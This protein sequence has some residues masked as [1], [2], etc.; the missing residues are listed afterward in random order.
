MKIRRLSRPRSLS[1]RLAEWPSI[2]TS[3]PLTSRSQVGPAR[4]R[5]Q[6]GPVAV[7]GAVVAFAVA[8]VAGEAAEIPVE[9]LA[10]QPHPVAQAERPRHH[11]ARGLCAA[12]PVVHVVLLEGAGGAE[13]PHAGETN[14]FLDLGRRRLVG[15]DPSPDLGLLGA[16]RVPAP[17]RA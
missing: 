7:K 14:G 11:A 1:T 13:Y 2:D 16:A 3:L 10:P 4:A 12:L 5:Q 8:I 15:V 9:A 17:D 6:A